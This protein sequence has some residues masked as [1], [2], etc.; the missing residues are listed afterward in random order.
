MSRKTL[1]LL[2]FALAGTLLSPFASAQ[3]T[4][5][6]R[7]LFDV[8]RSHAPSKKIPATDTLV[9]IAN[10]FSVLPSINS[11]PH[12]GLAAGFN[13]NNSFYTSDA[14]L[15]KMSTISSIPLYTQKK[16]IIIP[17]QYSIWTSGS[18]FNLMGDLRF[19]KYPSY[20]FGLGGNTKSTDGLLIRYNYFRAYQSVLRKVAKNA[21]L[22][23]GYALDKHWNIGGF[24]SILPLPQEEQYIRKAS[25]TIASGLLFNALYDSREN[26]VNPAKGS[27]SNL[28]FRYN[29][30]WLGNER[31]WSSLILEARRYIPLSARS[32]QVLAFWSYDW[33]LLSGTAPYFDLPST[34]WDTYSN[35]ARGYPQNRLRSKSLLY[36]E[37]EYRFDVTRNGLIGGVLFA[38][39]QTLSDWNTNTYK[40]F[41]PG[42]GLGL[43][44]KLHK[45][46]G[47]NLAFDYGFGLDGS[48]G[49]YFNLGE[50]F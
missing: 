43:R 1:L 4:V 47:I 37:S 33:L 49:F 19:Y 39:V 28:T 38:N 15:T 29:P 30:S 31:A 40:T 12:T 23:M 14:A 41:W 16:Q 8:F 45:Q 46:T 24:D 32:H 21:F 17:I 7:D 27:Y 26:P 9:H 10:V 2:L 34:G 42:Y 35:M 18:K 48:R 6:D 22:G 11:A 13:I 50:V 36:L 3:N 5:P 44:L 25:S 20:T